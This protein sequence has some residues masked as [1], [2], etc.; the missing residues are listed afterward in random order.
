MLESGCFN[1][2]SPNPNFEKPVAPSLSE[3]KKAY[4]TTNTGQEEFIASFAEYLNNPSTGKIRMHDA[5]KKFGPMPRTSYSKEQI[6]QMGVYMYKTNLEEDSWYA[7]H[8]EAEKK[9][10]SIPIDQLSYIDK[11]MRISMETKSIL[12]K[13]LLNAIAS[14]GTEGAIEF[15]STKALPLTD[16]MSAVY[17]AIVKRVS[18]KNR[19]P[20]N[21]A[22]PSELSYINQGKEILGK[23]GKIM[24]KTI[25]ENGK[26]T[27]YYPILADKMCLQCHGKKAE[28]IKPST[29]QRIGALYPADR[30]TGYDTGQL[31][32]IWVIEMKKEILKNKKK[33]PSA[34]PLFPFCKTD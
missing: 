34:Q 13:N 10:H 28:Q 29:L 4:L 18:D 12:G 5:L 21:T 26:V 23:G 30:A 20:K 1:C 24:P 11:G 31:R 6:T 17:H 16:S 27:G 9:K 22:N 15:C 8:F 32:G 7:S 19:N 3:I 2:H 33:R 14:K 25:E